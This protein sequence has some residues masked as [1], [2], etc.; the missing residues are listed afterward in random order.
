[1][2]VIQTIKSWFYPPVRNYGITESDIATKAA[3]PSVTRQLE[4]VVSI[5][6]PTFKGISGNGGYRTFPYQYQDGSSACVA[7]TT[8]KIAMIV[9]SLIDT[10]TTLFSAGWFYT[11][12]INTPAEGMNFDDLVNIAAQKG[13]LVDSMLPCF[14]YSENAM[15]TLLISQVDI[16]AAE[17]YKLPQNWI[18]IDN[19]DGG[20][21]DAVASTI[22]ITKKPVMLWF[23]FGA[24][25][26]FFTQY[27]QIV[28]STNPWRHSTCAVDTTTIAGKQY[29]V[30]EESADSINFYR[31]FISK[32]FFIAKC[33]LA[34]YPITFV[35]NEVPNK[36]QFDGSVK[37][38]QQC[39]QYLKFFPSNI[40][41]TG[42]WGKISTTACAKFQV[43]NGI[44]PALGNLGDITKASLIEKFNS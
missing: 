35:Y 41:C 29:I 13:C 15:N 23:E 19:F 7:F 10:S 6:T 26:F 18:D 16:I 38:A 14:G 42:F 22:E 43:A 39:L 8:A 5:A 4:V 21:F 9:K 11:Q 31:K 17:Q 3:S 27:P 20:S 25:E 36:P 1:M 2:K 28:S 24:G 44:T 33:I 37:S 40:A 32:E 30:I 34:R 12:R